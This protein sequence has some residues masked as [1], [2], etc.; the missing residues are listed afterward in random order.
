M[1][2]WLHHARRVRRDPQIIASFLAQGMDSLLDAESLLSRWQ[3][4]PREGQALETLLDE[5]TT[6]GHAAHLADFWQV[7]ALCE[8]LLDLYGAVEEGRLVA[9]A[10]FFVQARQAHERLLDMFDEIGRASCRER[11]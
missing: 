5:L 6:L 3:E 7:D 8:A 11:V 1:R 2:A 4:H 9:D 10:R